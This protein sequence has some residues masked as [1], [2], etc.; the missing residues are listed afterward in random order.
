M[1]RG[2]AGRPHVTPS[3]WVCIG[4]QRIP[5]MVCI[6]MLKSLNH[7]GPTRMYLVYLVYVYGSRA[8]KQLT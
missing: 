6:G 7:N 1:V 3:T 4:N 8:K 2:E 5:N